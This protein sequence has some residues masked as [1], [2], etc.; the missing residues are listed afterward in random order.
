MELMKKY[1]IAILID[2]AD[3]NPYAI[4][5]VYSRIELNILKEDYAAYSNGTYT[6]GMFKSSWAQVLQYSPSKKTYRFKDLFNEGYD[7]EF[8]VSDDGTIAQVPLTAILTGYV[9][10]TYGMVSAQ[11]QDGSMFDKN[12]TYTFLL[13]FTVSAGSFGIK[14]EKYVITNKL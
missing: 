3:T 12:S 13:K 8:S 1:H 14:T 4:Q 2:G 5:T 7:Y 11:A 10:P 9:H 6:S